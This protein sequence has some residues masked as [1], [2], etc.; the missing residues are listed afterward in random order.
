VIRPISTIKGHTDALD[1]KLL[2]DWRNLHVKSFLTEFTSTPER[3]NAWLTG[4]VHSNMGKMLFMV[5]TPDGERVG[6]VGLVFIDWRRA[7]GEADAIVS[8]G[9]SPRGL[10]KSS[11]LAL[12]Q[13]ARDA[14]GLRTLAV[15]VRSDN[16]AVDFYRKV[17][18]S[19]YRRIPLVATDVPGG[20]DWTEDPDAV[21]ASA[22]LVYMQLELPS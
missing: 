8:G 7:Y 16:S 11:L 10:M 12:M 13:W 15:R 22:S 18:F 9:N 5:E 4:P 14:L 20:V 3:T 19:E 1:V 6:H 17:G 2:T 21:D